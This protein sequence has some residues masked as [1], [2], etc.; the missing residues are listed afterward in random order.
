MKTEEICLNRERNVT[1]TVYHQ[2]VGE[3]YANICKRPAVLILPGGGYRFCSDKEA[4]PV[5]LVYLKAGYQVFILRYSVM[6][7]AVWPNPLKDYEQ[8]MSM[9]RQRAD[10]WNLYPDKI[11]VIGFSAGGHLCACAAAMSENRPN[12]AILGYPV[13]NEEN[14]HIWEKTA[15]DAVSAVDKKTCPCFVFATR[16]DTVVPVENALQFV[17]ALA[18]NDVS[19]ECHIYAYGPHGVSVA[20]ESVLVPGTKLCSRVPHW[21]ND[22]VEWLKDMFGTFDNGKMTE[23]ACDAHVN[24]NEDDEFSVGCTIGYLMTNP[25]TAP[26][27]QAMMSRGQGVGAAAGNDSQVQNM[28]TPESIQ[29]MLQHMRLKDMLYMVQTPEEQIRALD[30]QLRQISKK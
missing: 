20:D 7:H 22:S 8:A 11:A 14:A 25:Q 29:A 6:E 2:P 5:A 23:P 1:L 24:A 13:I 30:E 9:I 18:E 17:N 27:L 21:A 3:E 19:F 10:E 28:M 4:D 16:D 26:V 15:P 12:A